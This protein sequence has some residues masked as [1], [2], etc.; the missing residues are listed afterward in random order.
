MLPGD[1]EELVSSIPG[2]PAFASRIFC[3]CRLGKGVCDPKQEAH[4]PDPSLARLPCPA[5]S[6]LAGDDVYRESGLVPAAGKLGAASAG[7]GD[8]VL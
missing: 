5:L 6:G 8:L 3:K 1:A 7:D 2:Q 4:D